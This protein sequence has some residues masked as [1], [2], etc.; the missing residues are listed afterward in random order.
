[1]RTT[2]QIL[3]VAALCAGCQHLEQSFRLERAEAA[4]GGGDLLLIPPNVRAVGSDRFALD[5]PVTTRP[6]QSGCARPTETHGAVTGSLAP[7]FRSDGAV[8]ATFRLVVRRVDVDSRHRLMSVWSAWL[9]DAV[10]GDIRRCLGEAAL[11]GIG[12]RL[13]LERP[14]PMSELM[15]AQFSWQKEGAS[16]APRATLLRPGMRVCAVDAVVDPRDQDKWYHPSTGPACAQ[17]AQRPKGGLL[18][19]AGLGRVPALTTVPKQ[20]ESRLVA[21]WGEMPG[22]D[23]DSSKAGAFI[24]RQPRGLPR[25]NKGGAVGPINQSLLIAAN[26]GLSARVVLACANEDT[27]I[28]QFCLTGKLPEAGK[29]GTPTCVTDAL[30]DPEVIADQQLGGPKPEP[31][32]VEHNVKC[33]HFGV[34][35]LVSAEYTVWAQKSPVDV[36]VGTT[37]GDL[38]DRFVAPPSGLPRI[39]DNAVASPPNPD[40]WRAVDRLRLQRPFR[41]LLHPVDLSG[42]GAAALSL[43]LSPGDELSW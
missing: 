37:L 31:H 34:R 9:E 32:Q 40:G 7:D 43:P 24:L 25:S 8:D 1:M 3:I 38:I 14:L 39:A 18:F 30:R 22:V 10:S 29:P 28:E 15:T 2:I 5:F 21:S 41:G 27:E 11:A 19:D 13:G 4:A 36:A 42:A 12:R 23:H 6:D 20:A 16:S 17:L 35:G 26:T 33:F